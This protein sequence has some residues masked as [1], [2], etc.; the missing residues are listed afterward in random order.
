MNGIMY[1]MKVLRSRGMRE[2]RVAVEAL[3]KA[4]SGKFGKEVVALL[5]ECL[6]DK[7]WFVREGA[8][9]ALGIAGENGVDVAIAIPG[10]F[11]CKTDE[12][13]NVREIGGWAL[14]KAAKGGEKNTREQ[15][16]AGINEFVRSKQFLEQAEMNGR[17]YIITAGFFSQLLRTLKEA[18][19]VA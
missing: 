17:E 6:K 18:E 12:N 7:E 8:A 19:K 13:M 16:V 9:K 2:Q 15:I 1:L 5:T 10:L 14:A 4:A 3:E 11:A